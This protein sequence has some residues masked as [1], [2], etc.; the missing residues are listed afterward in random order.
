MFQNFSNIATKEIASGF[1]CKLIHT[2]NN[3]INFLE[4]A[5]GSILPLHQ[6]PH[7]QSSFVLEGDF[8]MT[9]GDETRLLTVNTFALIPGNVMH[10]GKAITNCK[11]IDIFSPVREDYRSL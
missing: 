9:V 7:E 5:A 10:G 1:F 8:E 6:H 11:L 2:A 4:V 3:T